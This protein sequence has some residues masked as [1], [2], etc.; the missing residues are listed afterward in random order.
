MVTSSTFGR[1]D[2]LFGV[3]VADQFVAH[4]LA[5]FDQDIAVELRVGEFPHD[6]APGR[7]QGLQQLRHF[8][9]MQ[10]ADETLG[11]PDGAVVQRFAQGREAA[12]FLG[13]VGLRAH[14]RGV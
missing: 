11:R 7:R 8:G 12:C 6:F 14:A 10:C 9:R 1:G 2:Q 4:V 5:E 3:H 13:S